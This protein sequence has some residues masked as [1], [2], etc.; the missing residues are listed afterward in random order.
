[1]PSPIAHVSVGYAVWICLRDRSSSALTPRL[2]DTWLALPAA[3]FLSLLPDVD[4]VP[5]ILL[6]EL[7]RFHNNLTHSILAACLA[8]VVC[9]WIA[10]GLHAVRPALWFRLA[11]LCCGSHVAMDYFTGGRGVLL[12][13]PFSISRFQS[14][15]ILFHGLKW[16]AHLRD[17]THLVTLLNELLFAA[18]LLL[19]VHATRRRRRSSAS[20]S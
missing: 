7:H 5:G 13:W 9:G 1:M 20:A 2:R 15:V 14:P 17:G 8:A 12:F 4:A 16:S 3:L 18:S 11:L 10:R 6:G 19:L